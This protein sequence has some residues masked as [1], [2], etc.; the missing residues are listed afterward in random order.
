MNRVSTRTT[1]HASRLSPDVQPRSYNLR[2]NVDPARDP[3]HGQVEIVL[4]APRGTRRIELHA[5]ELEIESA[6]VWDSRGELGVGRVALDA[7]RGTLALRL[8]RGLAGGEA[9]LELAFRGT[10]RRDLRGLYLARSGKRRYAAT[11][12]EAADA[13]RFFPCFDEPD[14]KARFRLQ[15]TTP[16]RNQVVSNAPVE[17]E[18]RHGRRKTVV[19]RETPPLSTYLVALMV[20]ELAASRAR[21]LGR[22]PIRVWCVP[23]K[24]HLSGFA[25]ECAVESL[26]RLERYFGLPYPYEKL[27]LIAVPDFEFGAMEN[28]GAV[29]FRETLLLVDPRT[30]TLTE[31]KRVAEVIA[32]ELAHMWYGDLVT[33]AWWDDL[34]LNE[35][36][37]TWM[38][39]TVVDDWHPEWEVWLDFMHGRGAALA[40]DAL[41]NTHPIYAEVRTPEQATEN[42]DPITYEKGCSVVRMIERWLGAPTFRKGVRR[43]I[44]KHRESN[45]VAADLWAALEAAAGHPVAPVVR[46]WIERPGFPWVEIE[47][48]DSGASS[49]AV[50]QSRCFAS[51]GEAA[52]DAASPWPIPLLLR[53]RPARGRI[54]LERK[55]LE[56]REGRLRLS[57]GAPRWVYANA[58]ES[59][60]YRPLHRGVLFDAL[61]ADLPA[62]APTER[63]GFLSHQW[64]GVRADR[65]RLRELLSLVAAL[66]DEE[67]PRVLESAFGPLEWLCQQTLPE[68]DPGERK[69]F[70]GFLGGLFGPP[71]EA[72][73]WGGGRGEPHAS[74]LRR[75]V[76]VRLLGELAEDDGVLAE[77]EARF[78]GYLRDRASLDPNLAG[79]VVELAARRGGPRRF[80]AMLRA[81]RRAATPQE[82]TRFELALGSFRDEAC[83]GR[84][85]ELSLS[86][87]VPTQDV[88]PLLQRL[89]LNPAAAATTWSFIQTRWDVLQGRVSA[90]L[91]SRLVGSL[92]A[93]RERRYRAEVAR[94]FRAHPLP[95]ATRALRQTLERFELDAELRGRTARELR[96]WL[97]AR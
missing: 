25:L 4:H 13:R 74:R 75:A 59:G 81:M 17:R 82:R 60:F 85:L 53:V 28:A 15:V 38:A 91:A 40:L 20:G 43:Y 48:K 47:R 26:R 7:V 41:A 16:A 21:R 46:A 57:R 93:L 72:L 5:V 70:Q 92:H 33:M 58:D 52:A 19:F 1:R 83:I 79:A 95:S 54:R 87:Q 73:A 31:R 55:L 66:G 84:A 9:R 62:L 96:A 29:T 37:A 39:Y 34:W 51:P 80:D 6:R 50:A 10:L 27:D 67:E 24:E 30:I 56:A 12:L 11:Q 76:L 35:A 8:G 23:G 90:G 68:L 22:T 65:A 71:F 77:A 3:Y 78:A 69:G 89:L 63:M 18:L 64:A 32:H 61:V 45:A 42:F 14:K 97:S 2:L 44:R 86:E 94:F 36:F 88:V 49:L